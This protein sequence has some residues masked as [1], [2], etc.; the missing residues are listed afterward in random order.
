LLL[1]RDE[2]AEKKLAA[3]NS[4]GSLEKE[5]STIEKMKEAAE[6]D[7]LNAAE[8]ITSLGMVNTISIE[9]YYYY[10]LTIF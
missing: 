8:K 5:V 1:L 6:N 10:Y 7:A 4:L 2:L 9:N 3:E